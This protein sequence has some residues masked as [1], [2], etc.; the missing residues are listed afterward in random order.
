M[1]PSPAEPGSSQ[2]KASLAL[3][4]RFSKLTG[5]NIL[6]NLTVPLAGL[7]DTA[8]L[9]HL[10][11]IHFLAGVALGGVIFDFIYWTFGVLR[12]GAT[13][14]TAQALGRDDAVEVE[15]ILRRTLVLALAGAMLLLLGQRLIEGAAFDLLAGSPEVEAA[16][17]EYFRARIWGAPAAL[18]NLAFLGWFLGREESRVALVMT[19]GASLSNVLLNLIFIV[20]LGLAARGAGIAT[21]LAQCLMLALALLFYRRR[22]G[23]EP[24][25]LATLLD[26]RALVELL[27]LQRDI[28][29]R[30][31]CLVGAFAVFTDA[32]ARL[33]TTVLAANTLLI[34]L[35]TFASH[36]IDG[37]AFAVESL[38]GRFSG[39][40]DGQRLRR[41][42]ALAGRWALGF[43]LGFS[44]LWLVLPRPILGLLTSHRDVVQLAI[45]FMPW[46]VVTMVLGAPAYILDGFF[47]GLAAGTTLRRAM[48]ISALGVFAPLAAW[49]TWIG[50]PTFLWFALAAFMVARWLTLGRAALALP[51][52]R[53][54]I[55]D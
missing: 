27:T 50:S 48:L 18:A 5:L 7:V 25:T 49:A 36:C 35:L 24:W 14:T 43:A 8:M 33:G 17:R 54:G 34:R 31:L 45:D 52:L 28:L 30:T 2:A 23:H 39:E 42:L 46:L 47:L 38:A 26:R 41:L 12:M 6:A 51:A 9:G 29:V 13:G 22:R 10:D 53:Q 11:S 4:R 1:S 3:R 37:A 40:G 32:S 19:L 20:H 15:R 21:A 16:G 44:F 55:G